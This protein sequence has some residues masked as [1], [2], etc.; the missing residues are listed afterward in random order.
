[1]LVVFDQ[2]PAV[3]AMQLSV[4]AC[5]LNLLPFLLYGV[6]MF[7]L[8]VVA[9]APLFAGLVLWVP[10]AVISGYTSYRDIFAAPPG[11]L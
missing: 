6:I 8:L 9:V 4:H 1:M 7:G 11:S 10:L 2:V 3:R 5:A